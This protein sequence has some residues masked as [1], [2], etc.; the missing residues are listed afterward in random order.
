MSKAQDAK[1]T[2]TSRHLTI[3]VTVKEGAA[4]RTSVFRVPLEDLATTEVN[5]LGEVI[6]SEIRRRLREHWEEVGGESPLF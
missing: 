2:A 3:T 6:D 5:L 4:F 1:I